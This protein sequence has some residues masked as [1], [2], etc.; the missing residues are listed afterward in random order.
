VQGRSVYDWYD[1][2]G[3]STMLSMIGSV[4]PVI[5]VVMGSGT[6][7]GTVDDWLV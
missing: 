4:L 3:P 7:T 1:D 6:D 2:T 5:G